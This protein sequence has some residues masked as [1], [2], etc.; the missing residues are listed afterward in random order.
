MLEADMIT[1]L[2][3][4]MPRVNLPWEKMVKPIHLHGS[5]KNQRSLTTAQVIDI[6]GYIVHF[7]FVLKFLFMSANELWFTLRIRLYI[8]YVEWQ[9]EYMLYVM[10]L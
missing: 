5:G 8:S 4:K 10:S 3:T 2:G 6:C 1:F 7:F 9:G